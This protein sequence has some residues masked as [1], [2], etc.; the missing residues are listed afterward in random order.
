MDDLETLEKRKKGQKRRKRLLGIL[1]ILFCIW[2]GFT[3]RDQ[4]STLMTKKE[5]LSKVQQITDQVKL[6]NEELSYQVNRLNDKE[7]IAEIARRDYHLSK[8]GEV[9]FITPDK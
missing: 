5:E 1:M 8:P 4:Q 6:E 3:W 7:Y 2:A 9:I